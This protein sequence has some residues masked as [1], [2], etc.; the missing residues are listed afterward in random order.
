M[1]ENSNICA[2]YKARISHN[3]SIKLIE[4]EC[5][6]HHSELKDLNEVL[7]TYKE[8][9][10]ITS[11]NVSKEQWSLYKKVLENVKN[12]RTLRKEVF[13]IYKMP[14]K[15]RSRID[16][17]ESLGVKHTIGILSF[18]TYWKQASIKLH[19]KQIKS[20]KEMIANEELIKQ[21][22]ERIKPCNLFI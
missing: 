22:D 2:L 20:Q 18:Y 1:D 5:R 13:D 9:F 10:Q 19:T 7:A 14:P 8:S 21:L 15:L 4:A 3:S 16:E 11:K 6:E 17:Y 12:I